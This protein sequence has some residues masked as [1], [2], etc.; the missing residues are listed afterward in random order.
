MAYVCE[1]GAGQRVYLDNQGTQT[2]VTLA[3]S[4]P[5][6][7]QQATTSVQTGSWIGPPQAFQA[8]SGVVIKLQ[9][10]EAD[11]F[12]QIQGSSISL[13]NAGTIE[14]A[15]PLAMQQAEMPMMPSMEPMQ[16]MQPMQ[17][18]TMGNMSMRLNPMKM[19]MGDMEMRMRSESSA[20]SNQ[21]ANQAPNQATNQASTDAATNKR[22]C[23]Q[24]G[25][26]VKPADRFCSSCGNRLE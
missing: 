5:G 15:Q 23:N 8:A 18:M 2:V 14:T 26:A 24:C 1:L 9:L 11:R 20:S 4:S 6:Q 10:S 3:S 13:V 22:F 12:I 21:A 17:P 16:P 7:Q 19:R 25:S